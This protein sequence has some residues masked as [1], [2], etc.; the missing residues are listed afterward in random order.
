MDKDNKY[1]LIINRDQNVDARSG[2]L[3]YVK[4]PP[5]SILQQLEISKIVRRI[6]P[7]I[8][9]ATY[10]L[11]IPLLLPKR[12]KLITSIYDLAFS[13]F[14][15]QSRTIFHRLYYEIFIRL[16]LRKSAG[17]LVQSDHTKSDLEEH[18]RYMDACRIYPGF[19]AS[20]LT[21]NRDF[22]YISSKYGVKKPYLLYVGANKPHKNLKSLVNAFN[23]VVMNN[24]RLNLSLIIAG[25]IEKTFYDIE[26]DVA[27]LDITR[28]VSIT[29]YVSNEELALL[30]ENAFAYVS[31][32]Y[33]ESG[34]CYPVLEAQAA[35]KPVLVSEIDLKE[36]C[37]ESALYFNPYD[38]SDL[39]E[40]LQVMIESDSLREELGRLG[41]ENVKKFTARRCASEILKYFE[42][43]HSG[44]ITKDGCT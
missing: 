29:G 12:V 27:K 33:L 40:K 43:I 25:P 26:Q 30:Y 2:T 37:G 19:E 13:Y 36:L 28:R 6:N 31:P 4:S 22:G 38:T 3:V 41:K 8:Y 35:G 17:V 18:F 14:P 42:A 34:Y 32:A 20:R 23:T 11:D 7:D 44:S 9:Y 39:V 16:A 10:F 5:L 21:S 15:E 1:Y 24:N